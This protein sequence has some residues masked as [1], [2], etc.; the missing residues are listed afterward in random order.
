MQELYVRVM[1][2]VTGVGFRQWVAE[3]AQALQLTGWVR[4]GGIGSVEAVFQGDAR[5][6]GQMYE[7]IRRGPESANVESAEDYWRVPGEIYERFT[8]I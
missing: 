6:L 3:Q 2:K 7:L 8:V 1:G 5:R 4:N